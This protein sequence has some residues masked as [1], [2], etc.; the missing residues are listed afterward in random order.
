MLKEKSPL[1]QI[2]WED[3]KMKVLV[4]DDDPAVAHQI[5]QMIQVHCAANNISATTIELTDPNKIDIK[6]T[7]DIAFLDIDMPQTNGIKLAK[8]L[9]GVQKDTIIIFVTN[10]IQ[11]APDGYEVGAFRYL[12]K[13]KI[14]DK[15]PL[16]F[17]LAINEI[18]KKRRIVTIQINGERIDIPVANIR[19][20]ESSGRIVTIHLSNDL[21]SEYRFYGNMTDLSQKFE[22]LGFLRVHKSYLVNMRYIKIFQCKRLELNDGF[23]IPI[24]ER[25]YSQLKQS[26]LE[27]ESENKWNI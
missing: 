13:E 21:R 14:S 5:S 15:L 12:M 7:Y 6:V 20:L 8:K 19:Y 10:F 27:W 22:V 26:Y 9:R 17:D 1:A 23:L 2:R 3:H 18:V 4:C 11:Y 24:S 16:Y 25:K